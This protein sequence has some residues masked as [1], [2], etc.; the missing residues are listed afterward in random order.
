[1]AFPDPYPPEHW[2]TSS[3]D[4]EGLEFDWFAQDRTGQ[5][6]VFTS[7]GKGF[8]PRSVFSASVGPYNDFVSAIANR[9][10]SAAIL[11]FSGDGRFQDWREFAEHGLF[12]YDFQDLH[13]VGG[14]KRDGYD[15]MYG[16]SIPAT[17]ADLP[18]HVVSYLPVLDTLF[19]NTDI[20]PLSLIRELDG[21]IS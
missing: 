18:V 19:G 11:E 5:L 12:S 2:P 7:A 9:A 16:P 4:V 17:V 15:L 10:V 6:A 8:I 20:I 3:F 14:E 1:M 13:R 21:T